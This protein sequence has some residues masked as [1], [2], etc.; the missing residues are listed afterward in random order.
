MLSK[1][2]EHECFDRFI[3]EGSFRRFRTFKI[4]FDHVCFVVETRTKF[5]QSYKFVRINNDYK[6]KKHLKPS[7]PL[8]LFSKQI[9]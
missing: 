2:L 1:P 7:W 5:T 8:M 3:S 4:D 6:A 9:S